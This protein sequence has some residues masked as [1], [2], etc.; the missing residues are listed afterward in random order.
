MKE[1]RTNLHRLCAAAIRVAAWASVMALTPL[2]LLAGVHVPRTDVGGHL[3]HVLAYAGTAL[4]V[5]MATREG[6]IL[7]IGSALIAYAGVL[8]FLQRYA[9]GRTSS[10]RDFLHSAGGVVLGCAVAALSMYLA[11]ARRSPAEDGERP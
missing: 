7:R 1:M 5:A 9:P 10:L 4:F 3:E 6:A 2:S 11:A 8:E